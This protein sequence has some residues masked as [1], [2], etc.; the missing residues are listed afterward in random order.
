LCFIEHGAMKTWE[1]GAIA[2]VF[3]TSVL[4]GDEWSAS[5]PYRYTLGETA[6]SI[7]WIGGWV[8][9]RAGLDAMNEKILVPAGIRTPTFQPVALH[10]D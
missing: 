6:Q 5:C 7:Y 8:S 9:T 1:V 2:P 4:D 10:Y 3:L